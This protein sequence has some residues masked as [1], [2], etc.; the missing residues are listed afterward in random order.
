M[1]RKQYA[2]RPWEKHLE[3]FSNFSYGLNTV[4]S[5]ENMQDTEL[6]DICNHDLAELGAVKRRY[7]MVQHLNPSIEG[8]GQGYF[9][10]YKSGTEY[11]EINTVGGQ[12]VIDGEIKAV[13]GLDAFQTEKTI[14]AV[15]FGEKLYI[16]TGTKLVEYDGETFKVAEPYKP[17]PLE[18]LYIGTNALADNP[19][20]FM[21]D[22][23]AIFPRIDGVTFSSR[24]GVINESVTLTAYVSKPSEMGLEFQ[25]E[26]R[27]PMMEEGKWYLG[28]DW[29]S[30]KTYKFTAEATGDV[31]FRVNG[32]E[33]GKTVSE[34]QYLIP[35]FTVKPAKDEKDKE[36]DVS[37][38]HTCNRIFLHWNRLIIYGDNNNPDMIYISHLNNPNYFPIPH[39]LRF[40]NGKKEALTTIVRYRDMLV[41]FTRTT[42]QALF[43]KSPMEFH[44]V[45][46]NTSIGCIAPKSAVVVQNHIIFLSS[47]GVYVLKSVGYVED[48][49]NVTKIDTKIDNIIPREEDACAIFFD[50]QYQ[51]VFPSK[52]TRFR[53]YVENGAWV[54]DHS[55]KLDFNNLYERDGELFGQS[56]SGIVMRFDKS[57]Y[58]DDEYVYEDVIETKGFSF[59][60]PYHTKKLKEIQIMTSPK[61]G[62]ISTSVYVYADSN[63]V[64]NPNQ[65]YAT[66]DPETREVKWIPKFEPN[67]KAESGTVF[68]VWDLGQDGFG[69]TE[70]SIAKLPISGKCYTTKIRIVH[71]EPNANILLGIAY[72]FKIKKP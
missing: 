23:E 32:R 21:K 26:W 12:F 58:S 60:Q 15:Q 62:D 52:Q 44:R 67:V 65:S 10:F 33:A 48:K 35:K 31:Q 1:A 38:I 39:C 72:I 5:N 64:I 9:R 16:A 61:E 55:P 41:A 53:M 28:Q 14:E 56:I 13:E 7:G 17:E 2:T 68:G 43:G 24:Y 8:L 11:I 20:D 19:S 57:V 59:G 69:V 34:I 40:E 6:R 27:Y 45:M 22:G 36:E 71:V 51:I 3:E 29:S 4:A 54:K 50:N 37:T 66:I 30:D 49:A 42:V 46:L 25:F 47:E 63:S 18:A 70:T